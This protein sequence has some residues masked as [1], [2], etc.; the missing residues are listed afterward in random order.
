ML[1]F[2]EAE[3]L[4]ALLVQNGVRPNMPLFAGAYFLPEDYGEVEAMYGCMRDPE[5]AC[6]TGRI[7]ML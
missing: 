4:Q 3:L 2:D 6:L 7:R 5:T 1:S